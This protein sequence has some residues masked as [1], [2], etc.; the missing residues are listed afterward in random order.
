MLN[1]RQVDDFLRSWKRL[2][3]DRLARL[4]TDLGWKKKKAKRTGRRLKR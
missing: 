3:A 4:R 2:D 1:A